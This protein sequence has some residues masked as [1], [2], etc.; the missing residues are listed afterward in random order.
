MSTMVER[1]LAL[2]DELVVSVVDCDVHPTALSIDEF[3]P[4]VPQPWR[5]RYYSRYAHESK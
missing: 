5:D 4:Y 3:V 2:G 1:P